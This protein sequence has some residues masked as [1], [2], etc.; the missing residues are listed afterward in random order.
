MQNKD[1]LTESLDV[2][3]HSDLWIVLSF[4]NSECDAE[5]AGDTLIWRILKEKGQ[6]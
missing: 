5:I 1:A 4:V 6:V 3:N 2:D